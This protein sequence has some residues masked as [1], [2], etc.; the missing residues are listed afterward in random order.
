MNTVIF[1]GYILIILRDF[2]NT[3]LWIAWNI[4]VALLHVVI[5]I[6]FG[7]CAMIQ[8][9]FKNSYITFLASHSK[10]TIKFRKN[11]LNAHSPVS[12]IVKK[13]SELEVCNNR[14]EKKF[15][16]T[17]VGTKTRKDTSF[18]CKYWRFCPFHWMQGRWFCLWCTVQSSCHKFLRWVV[19]VKIN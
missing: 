5:P 8:P 2:W 3:L 9:I 16:Y 10:I 12:Q 13:I 4:M 17:V 1:E 14:Y 6:V 15:I 11:V 18:F 19:R 7:V